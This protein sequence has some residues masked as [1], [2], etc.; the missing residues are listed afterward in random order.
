MARRAETTGGISVPFSTSERDRVLLVDWAP[1]FALFSERPPAR[2]GEPCVALAFHD[3][4]VRACLAMVE[5]GLSHSRHRDLVLS[6]GVFMNRILCDALT[7]KL[8]SLRVNVLTH[9]AVPPNDGG[10]ALGQAV[11]GGC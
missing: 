11:A 5:F 2:G 3:A 4:L 8:K 9:G 1:A 10:I 6:G 7:G